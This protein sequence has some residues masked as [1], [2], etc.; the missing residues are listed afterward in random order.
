M[1]FINFVIDLIV[2]MNNTVVR[3][4]FSV[5]VLIWG[6]CFDMHGLRLKDLEI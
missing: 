3:F 6:F 2:V 1:R 5:R 4:V